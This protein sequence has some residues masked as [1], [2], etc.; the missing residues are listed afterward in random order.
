MHAYIITASFSFMT[1]FY[2]ICRYVGLNVNSCITQVLMGLPVT[3]YGLCVQFPLV[4]LFAWSSERQTC[5]RRCEINPTLRNTWVSSIRRYSNR[6]LRIAPPSIG[7]LGGGTVV[8][9]LQLPMKQALRDASKPADDRQTFKSW[10]SYEMNNGV[11][12]CACE[13]VLNRFWS[14]FMLI[15]VR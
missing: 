13:L 12:L 3:V 14:N 6:Y 5:D 9:R 15:A 10:I 4:L 1:I 11:N 2:S 7:R 8:W